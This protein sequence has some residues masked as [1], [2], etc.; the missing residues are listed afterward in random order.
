L[1][2]PGT[3][4]IPTKNAMHI[5]INND[6]WVS[7]TY[8]DSLITNNPSDGMLIKINANG[9]SLT[10]VRFGGPFSDRIYNSMIDNDGNIVCAGAKYIAINKDNPW[11]LKFD[12]NGNLLWENQMSITSSSFTRYF[13]AVTQNND[14]DYFFLGNYGVAPKRF[15]HAKI[16]N[17]GTTIWKT[18]TTYSGMFFYESNGV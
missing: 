2:H 11:A 16:Q 12:Q 18:I 17:D 5:G 7:C 9:D 14:G 13:E 3:R 4:V 10:S 1:S 6:I 15:F 8:S